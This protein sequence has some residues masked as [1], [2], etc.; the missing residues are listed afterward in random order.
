M[1]IKK[2]KN[3]K[4]KWTYRDMVWS[5][6]I[7]FFLI[8]LILSLRISTDQNVTNILSIG[9]SLISIILGIVAIL[10]SIIQNNSSARLD[11]HVST[12]LALINQRLESIDSQINEMK[13]Y[14]KEAIETSET[15][16]QGEK[17]TRLNGVYSTSREWS[18]SKFINE[19]KKEL[20]KVN[21]EYKLLDYSIIPLKIGQDNVFKFSTSM[22]LLFKGHIQN[23]IL[24]QIIECAL[25]NIEIDS[26]NSEVY[27]NDK[28]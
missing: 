19:I 18:G 5:V 20:H 11:G 9:G 6:I 10:V 13:P 28:L 12:T 14:S 3:D 7:L 1:V 27:I 24:Q 2:N 25:N 15:E 23:K 4:I 21:P 26:Y 17:T 16:I 8:I 22:W